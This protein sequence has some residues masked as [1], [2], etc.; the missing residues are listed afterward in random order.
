MDNSEREK[1]VVLGQTIKIYD[2]VQHA[3]ANE[4]GIGFSRI[5]PF[6]YRRHK[7]TYQ[8]TFVHK[9]PQNANP[10]HVI[11]EI[12]DLI[13]CLAI[14]KKITDIYSDFDDENFSSAVTITEDEIQK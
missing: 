10:I 2:L 7:G 4:L 6:Y 8:F 12:N 5:E 1:S 9:P 3:V 14:D 11:L 13:D